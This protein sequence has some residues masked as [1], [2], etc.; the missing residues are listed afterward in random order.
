ME[1][2]TIFMK[3]LLGRGHLE[4][5]NGVGRLRHVS[6]SGYW[7]QQGSTFRSCYQQ[8]GYVRSAT[9]HRGENCVSKIFDTGSLQAARC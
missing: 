6:S 1:L 2:Y 5:R 7:H 4:D 3:H 9:Y 8:V